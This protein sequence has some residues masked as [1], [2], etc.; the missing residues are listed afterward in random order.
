MSLLPARLLDD[1]ARAGM[2]IDAN[3]VR[4]GTGERAAGGAG[5]GIEFA[6]HR[7]YQ[8]GDD[9]RHLDV[10]AYARFR[11]PYVKEY[12]PARPAKVDL[13]IDG[14]ESMNFGMPTKFT[15]ARGLA[16]GLACIALSASDQ[17]RFF[18]TGSEG[19][20]STARIVGRSGLDSALRWLELQPPG[21]A[22]DITSA[23]WEAWSQSGAGHVTVIVSDF[24]QD[25]FDVD[26]FRRLVHGR[27]AVV[28][29]L[30]AREEVE[31]NLGEGLNLLQDAESGEEV[32]VPVH[33][34][35]LQRYQANLSDWKEALGS[36]LTSA[37]GKYLSLVNDES[38]ESAFFEALPRSRVLR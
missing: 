3:P 25:G 9:L 7:A 5:A 1:L 22:K 35:T 34:D 26:K 24:L 28:V 14:S 11:V 37:G 33:R 30:L 31:P 13:L 2:Q 15:F 27:T 17:V 20:K 32:P 4:E 12:H 29:H 18:V 36:A 8:P 21:G 6:D 19:M 38:L 16:A 10:N 23:V